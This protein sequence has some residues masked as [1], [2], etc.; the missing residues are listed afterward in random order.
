VDRA[1]AG[2]D[3]FAAAGAA[4]RV[5]WASPTAVGLVLMYL[6]QPLQYVPTAALCAVLVMALP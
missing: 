2:T 4:I 6:T 1:A 5:P 3:W